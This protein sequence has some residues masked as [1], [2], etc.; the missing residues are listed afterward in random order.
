MSDAVVIAAIVAVPPTL[1]VVATWWA[2]ET[3]RRAENKETNAKLSVIHKTVN[4]RLTAALEQITQLQG[5]IRGLRN[6]KMGKG[7]R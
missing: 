7:A 4:S 2:G 3:K 6:A 5:E 1:A